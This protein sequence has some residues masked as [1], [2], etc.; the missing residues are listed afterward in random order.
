MM[1]VLL[2]VVAFAGAA[3]TDIVWTGIAEHHGDHVCKRLLENG[4]RMERKGSGYEFCE[5]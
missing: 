1:F 2:V 4:K 3:Q 5:V